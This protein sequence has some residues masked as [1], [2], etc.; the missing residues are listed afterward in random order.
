M[1]ASHVLP[2]P[3]VA[4]RIGDFAL[5]RGIWLLLL[6]QILSGFPASATGIFLPDMAADLGTDVA[7]VGGLRGLGGAAALVCGVVAAPLIDRIA[8]AWAVSAGL[9]LLAVGALLAA[10]GSIPTLA[11]FFALAGAAGAVSDPALQSAA[12]DSQDAAT[13]ARAA[14]MISAFRALSPML[15]A[16]LLALPAL[17]WGWRG[18]FAAM[19]IS[20]LLV[21]TVAGATLARRPAADLDRPTY[22]AVLRTVARAPGALPLVMGSTLRATL[23]FA[24]LTYLAAFLVQRFGAST[25][26]VAVTWTLG[27]TAFFIANLTVGRLIGGAEASGWRAPERLLPAS[28]LLL[29][30]LTPMGLLAP[31]LYL[32]MLLAALTAGAHGAIVAGTI[33][34]LVRRYTT[35]RGAVLGLNAAGANL[36]LFA[37]AAIGGWALAWAGYSGLTETLAFLAVATSAVCVWAL[38]SAFRVKTQIVAH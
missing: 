13:G 17:Y 29:I 26:E 15:A 36:G 30:A 3:P 14:A 35:V 24:W 21:A 11:L 2:V 19:A 5:V 34:L 16:P 27:G 7:L 25:V 22:R 8:R 33:S 20:C 6:A 38:R 10:Y 28:L 9:S 31:T 4:D 1:T 37:G 32:A 18:D 12:A 23:Q